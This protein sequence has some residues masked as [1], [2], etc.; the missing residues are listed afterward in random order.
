MDEYNYE[1]EYNKYDGVTFFWNGYDWVLFSYVGAAISI[2]LGL[3]QGVAERTLREL[4]AKGDIRSIRCGLDKEDE[5][6]IIKPSEWLKAEVDLEGSVLQY[7]SVS[8]DDYRYWLRQQK[9]PEEL[10]ARD[11]VISKLLQAGECPPDK[12]P[13]KEFCDTVRDTANGWT[14]NEPSFG[15]SDKQIQRAVKILRTNRTS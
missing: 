6:Q 1:A 9:Q 3:S 7:V 13:W 8:L 14:N 5:A 11:T 4:C 12:L 15:F 10:S 2:T